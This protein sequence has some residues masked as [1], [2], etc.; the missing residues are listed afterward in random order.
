M[1]VVSSANILMF[2][3][4]ITSDHQKLKVGSAEVLIPLLGFFHQQKEERENSKWEGKHE[5]HKP[6]A[7]KSGRGQVSISMMN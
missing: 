7:D 1:E 3:S 5:E 4:I 2:A 6:N